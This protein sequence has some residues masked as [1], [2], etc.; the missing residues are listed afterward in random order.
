MGTFD[1]DLLWKDYWWLVLI[2]IALILSARRNIPMWLGIL[3]S[4]TM[5]LFFSNNTASSSIRSALYTT[6]RAFLGM[7]R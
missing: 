2:V 3:F 7:F 4:V 5:F 6:G 1:M